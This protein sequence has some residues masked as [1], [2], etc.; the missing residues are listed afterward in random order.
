MILNG[1]TVGLTSPDI[2]SL[3]RP[4][5]KSASNDMEDIAANSLFMTTWTFDDCHQDLIRIDEL[6][7]QRLGIIFRFFVSPF[8]IDCYSS[9]AVEFVR[10][11]LKDPSASLLTWDQ[12]G[13]LIE[14]GH[15]LGLHGYDH[16]DFNF[17]SDSL[18]FE[19]HERSIELLRRR[20]G[21]TTDSFAFPFGRILNLNSLTNNNQLII[22]KRYFDRIYISDNRLP[23]FVASGVFNRRH[24]EFGNSVFA[25]LIKGLLQHRFANRFKI[26]F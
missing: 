18:I 20:L 4:A 3:L 10:E 6:L 14:N 7:R 9:G 12:I 26:L 24:S 23:P 13:R 25:S 1:H 11:Q 5:F 22:S 16:S 2:I 8:L 19:Q 21:V 15:I 17:L